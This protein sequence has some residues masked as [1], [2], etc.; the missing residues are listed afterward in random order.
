MP[1]RRKYVGRE[2]RRGSA[3]EDRLRPK[4]FGIENDATLMTEDQILHL[5]HRRAIGDGNGEEMFP[6]MLPARRATLLRFSD[7]PVMFL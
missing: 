3:G 6:Q 1:L 2:D 4:I 5:L 7:I